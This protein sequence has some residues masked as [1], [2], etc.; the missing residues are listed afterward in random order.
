[1][2]GSAPSLPPPVRQRPLPSL[3]LSPHL[4]PD[5]RHEGVAPRHCGSNDLPKGRLRRR[6]G[7]RAGF[8]HDPQLV[9][10][11]L[12]CPGQVLLCG[13]PLRELAL[14]LLGRR[15][16]SLCNGLHEVTGAGGPSH[17]GVSVVKG[18]R[19]KS[20]RPRANA[21]SQEE[22]VGSTCLCCPRKRNDGVPDMGPTGG[23]ARITERRVVGHAKVT[24]RASCASMRGALERRRK[25]PQF[26]KEGPSITPGASFCRH[27]PGKPASSC[28]AQ[29]VEASRDASV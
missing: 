8:A 4:P 3:R 10:Q 18:D 12:R 5:E 27:V 6:L 21:A 26:N 28:S 7:H 1:M 15:K 2:S 17:L 29:C 11:A 9:P 20:I 16:K 25:C 19:R 13:A 22:D 14:E 24:Q 23:N